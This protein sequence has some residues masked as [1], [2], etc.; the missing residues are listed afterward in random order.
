MCKYIYIIIITPTLQMSKIRYG[1]GVV[2]RAGKS[3]S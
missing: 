1:V 3:H 2:K